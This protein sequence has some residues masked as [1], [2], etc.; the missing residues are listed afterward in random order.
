MAA[1]KTEQKSDGGKSY[2]AIDGMAFGSLTDPA[3]AE[4][5]KDADA[6]RMAGV[7]VAAPGAKP[8]SPAPQA[9]PV[10]T[11]SPVAAMAAAPAADPFAGL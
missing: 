9:A 3:Y 2:P 7:A 5:P 10:A 6:L 8:A 4:V 1:V 11:T